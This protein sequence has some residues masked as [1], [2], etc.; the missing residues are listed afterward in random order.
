MWTYALVITAVAIAGKLG[1]CMAAARAA[2][3]PW[4]ESAALGILMNTRG[5]MELVVLNIGLEIGVIS[6]RLF[7][8]MVLMALA[9]TVITTPLLRLLEIPG[10][11]GDSPARERGQAEAC[12]TTGYTGP[13]GT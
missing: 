10:G 9:T 12:P 1:G 6:T 7:S 8:A 3:M 5:L 11:A 13:A 4:R 2:G